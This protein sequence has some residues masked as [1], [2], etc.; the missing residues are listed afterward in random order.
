M[1]G[2]KVRDNVAPEAPAET[3]TPAPKDE[4]RTEVATDSKGRR[5]GVRPTDPVG[6]FDITLMLGENASNSAALNQALVACSVVSIN[7]EDVRPPVTM[8]QLRAR[9]ALLGFHGYSAVKEAL[10]RFVSD[11]EEVAGVE[12]AKN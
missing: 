5:I 8:L 9:M 1:A 4:N 12:A 2:L 10:D 11:E 6:L 3:T 7:G